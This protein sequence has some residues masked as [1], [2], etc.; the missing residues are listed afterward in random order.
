MNDEMTE[1]R[2]RGYIPLI[3]RWAASLSGGLLFMMMIHVIIDVAARILKLPLPGTNEVVAA[4]YM[5]AIV[6]LPLAYVAHLGANV[7]VDLFANRQGPRLQVFATLISEVLGL[8]VTLVWLRQAYHTA[9][10]STEITERWIIGSTFLQIWPGRW[11]LVLALVLLALVFLRSF[12][13]TVRH[14]WNGQVHKK[15]APTDFPADVEAKE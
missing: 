3:A 4:Y 10:H 9:Q 11:I 12:Y 13:L 5:I 2:V 15:A 7:T 1:E 14:I 6:F 8:V